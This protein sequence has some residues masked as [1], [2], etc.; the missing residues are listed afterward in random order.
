VLQLA[1][2]ADWHAAAYGDGGL[3][4]GVRRTSAGATRRSIFHNQGDELD[5]FLVGARRRGELALVV[6]VIGDVSHGNQP[7]PLSRSDACV[8]LSKMFSE[9]AHALAWRPPPMVRRRRWSDCSGREHR[10]PNPRR[11]ESQALLRLL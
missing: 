11:L 2:F 8:C 6:A 7:H 9:L 10:R 3:S 5:R 1:P 4:T